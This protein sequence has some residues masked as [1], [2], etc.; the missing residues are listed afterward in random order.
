MNSKDNAYQ[1][2]RD[3]AEL[4]AVDDE[5]LVDFLADEDTSQ[6]GLMAW[7]VRGV[8]DQRSGVVTLDDGTTVSYE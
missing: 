3:R 1:G 4:Y 8:L 5:S 6:N 7:F 2:G